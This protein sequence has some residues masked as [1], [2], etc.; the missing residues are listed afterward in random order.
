LTSIGLFPFF[1]KVKCKYEAHSCTNFQ[2]N[3]GGLWFRTAP[4]APEYADEH[5]AVD[6]TDSSFIQ[7]P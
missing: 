4:T 6:P 3:A 7:V 5:R 2:D 1:P